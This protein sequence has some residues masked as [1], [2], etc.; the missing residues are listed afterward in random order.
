MFLINYTGQYNK[1]ANYLRD[2]LNMRKQL[3]FH[4]GTTGFP[5]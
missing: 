3:A 4:N 5:G 1:L 2:I